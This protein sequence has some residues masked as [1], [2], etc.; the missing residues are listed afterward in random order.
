MIKLNQMVKELRRLTAAILLIQSLAI[1]A[2]TSSPVSSLNRHPTA[3]KPTVHCGALSD[4]LLKPAVATPTKT[5]F[6]KKT[7]VKVAAGVVAVPILAT[8]TTGISWY[9]Q[10]ESSQA[11]TPPGSRGERG[12]YVALVGDSLSRN[13]SLPRPGKFQFY[14]YLHEMHTEFQNDAFLDTSEAADSVYSFFE[15]AATLG[16]LKVENFSTPQARVFQGHAGIGANLRQAF[17]IRNLNEQIDQVLSRSDIPDV[18][19]LWLGHNDIDW[20]EKRSPLEIENPTAIFD[21][22][23][24]DFFKAYK[25]EL[26]RYRTNADGRSSR[27]KTVA[28]YGLIN[29]KSFFKA[30]RKMEA[31]HQDNPLLYPSLEMSVEA[32]NALK[33]DLSWGMIELA[34]RLNAGLKSMVEELNLGRAQ[35]TTEFVYLPALSEVVIDDVDLYNRVDAWHPSPKGRSNLAEA[36]FKGAEPILNRLAKPN[37]SSTGGDHNKRR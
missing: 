10:T 17:G 12:P 5:P 6:Y 33:P 36:M 29:F 32:Y 31:M 24:R 22:I 16:P 9:A 27:S 14:N 20:V 7:T 2:C 15:R 34:D 4:D 19:M 21:Q 25:F 28:V 1:A 3:D 37:H 18:L 30:R 23:E 35:S 26:E 8:T 11:E 13:F